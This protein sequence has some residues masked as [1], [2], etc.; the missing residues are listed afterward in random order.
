MPEDDDTDELEGQQLPRRRGRLR[1]GTHRTEPVH[2]D[3][4]DG[5]TW[6]E[7]IRDSTWFVPLLLALLAILLVLGAYAVG[8]RFADGVADR[9][10]SGSEPRS[11]VVLGRAG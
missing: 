6:F 10:S 2:D 11:A 1:I 8:R 4:E 3:E 9:A 7:R 5:P